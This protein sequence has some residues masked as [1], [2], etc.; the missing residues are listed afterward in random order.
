MA[1]RGALMVRHEAA[2]AAI[3]RQHI[4]RDLA[5]YDLPAAA[6]DDAVLVASEL[7][8]NAVR[9]TSASESNTLDVSW[10]VDPSGVR[11]CVGD[12]SDQRPEMRSAT[13]NEPSGRGLKIV[14][15]LADEW[16]V[17][18]GANGKVVWAHVPLQRRAAVG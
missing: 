17:E 11:V 5:S 7:V 13:I 18:R 16:G 15:A 9:H 4:A 6:I 10:D 3:V 14:D 1:M 2:S 8:G 12:P